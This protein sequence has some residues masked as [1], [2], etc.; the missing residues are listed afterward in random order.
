MITDKMLEFMEKN[1]IKK[2]VFGEHRTPED[3]PISNRSDME[4]TDRTLY[5]LVDGTEFILT[6]TDIQS[7]PEFVPDWGL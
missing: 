3:K 1:K 2:V 7:V 4:R 6:R 5:R